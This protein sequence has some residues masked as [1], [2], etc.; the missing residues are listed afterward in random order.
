VR[1][2]ER[3]GI[4]E[5]R[6]IDGAPPGVAYAVTPLGRSLDKPF[7][8]LNA[9]TSTHADAVRKAQRAFDVRY[10]VRLLDHLVRPQ[11]KRLRDRQAQRLGGLEVDN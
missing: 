6:I 10:G 3:N 2:L 4:V 8:A 1:R 5:R 11:Q 9:W 7:A